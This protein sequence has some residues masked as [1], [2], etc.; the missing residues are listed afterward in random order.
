MRAVKIDPV[1]LQLNN[2]PVITKEITPSDSI[3]IISFEL[4][5]TSTILSY[6]LMVYNITWQYTFSM[7]RVGNAQKV[8]L[9]HRSIFSLLK[10]HSVGYSQSRARRH[11]YR[12]EKPSS[13][14]FKRE[15]GTENCQNQIPKII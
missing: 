1:V 8:D 5:A 2:R 6:S 9:S 11:S 15:A 12:R 3:Q 4:I 13:K 7:L 10:E 14:L